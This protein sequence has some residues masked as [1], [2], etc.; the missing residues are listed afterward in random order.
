[1]FWVPQKVVWC[2]L[3]TFRFTS[4]FSQHSPI[5]GDTSPLALSISEIWERAVENSKKIKLAEFEAEIGRDEVREARFERLPEW[6][7]K[8]FIEHATNLAVYN[9]GL[10][11]KPEQHE[12]V[13]T[14]YK[15][16]TDLYLTLYNGNKI[17]LTID[18]KKIQREILD[19][20]RK[21]TSSEIKLRASF[22]YLDLQRSLI[23]KELLT[24][25]ILNQEKQLEE[26][27][28][29]LRNGVVLKSDELRVELK[30]SNQKLLLVQIENDIAIANQ[31]LNIIL[32]LADDKP[33]VPV[34][35]IDPE[36][37][38]PRAYEEY[39]EEA[40]HNSFEYH[41]SEK[42]TALKTLE[43]RYMKA[44]VS[45]RVGLYG[46]FFI[47]NPQI[48]LF[49]YSPSNYT[50]GV[51]GVKASFP[52]SALYMNA[53]KM[54]IATLELKKE[55][56]EHHDIEDKIRQQVYETYVRFHE[57]LTRVDVAR[58]NIAHADESAR[59]IKN[60]YVNQTALITDLL[61]ADI[62]VLQT[63]FEFASAR[64]EAQFRYYQLQNVLG[65][66]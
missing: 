59:I 27:R 53:P 7:I 58:V 20:Q 10:L 6:E 36:A 34:E 8:G 61:D 4:L 19:E 1:M 42:K 57:A 31:K 64:I 43:L 22:Y 30:L 50:L 63:R 55:E 12:V 56:M 17:N 32:G 48:F 46:D 16:G 44:N 9:H 29:L 40:F 25:D 60:N 39:L 5:S 65:N 41:I 33:V 11:N 51:V 21:F 49:P 66:L 52:V 24:R 35:K 38:P 14:L 45:P 15:L 28:H 47:S 23:Y 13:H 2:C 37:I 54:K 3:F 62:Q 18:K 26:I